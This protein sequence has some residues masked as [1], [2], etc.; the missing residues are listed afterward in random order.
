MGY[1]EAKASIAKERCG[2]DSSIAEL[3]YFICCS[4]M[5]KKRRKLENKL[6]KEDD[7][8][9]HLLNPM[10]GFGVITEPDQITQRTPLEDVIGP[11]YF[12]YEN[13]VLAPVCVWT[14]MSRFPLI[15]LPLRTIHDAFPLTKKWWPSWD[16]RTKLNCL[17][18]CTG[19]AKLTKRIRKALEAYADE[20]PSSVQNFPKNYTRGGGSA[21][22]MFPGGINVLSLFSEISDAEVAF[23][24]L[25]IPLETD[26][27]ELNGD[28]LEELMSRFGRFDLFIGGIQ[29]SHSSKRH[30]GYHLNKENDRHGRS[31][32]DVSR[33]EPAS[34]EHGLMA[35]ENNLSGDVYHPQHEISDNL[36]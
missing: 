1:S 4:Q 14:E 3:T 10:I 16:P 8:A 26:V 11:P 25:G 27:Q 29:F 24:C 9:I 12:Y 17:Q 34:R 21:K 2:S 35:G 30:N 33:L 31:N 18:T 13:V 32:N 36:S 6:L 20:P 15:P 7:H 23:Y 5:A 19:S 28:R 22:D